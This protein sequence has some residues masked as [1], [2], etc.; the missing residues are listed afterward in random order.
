MPQ[1]LIDTDGDRPTH[2][3]SFSYYFTI[4]IPPGL[5]SLLTHGY[6]HDRKYSQS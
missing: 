4:D 3:T 6:F 2:K 1:S 5:Y